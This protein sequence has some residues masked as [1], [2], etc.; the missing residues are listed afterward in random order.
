M[1]ARP[2]RFILAATALVALALAPPCVQAGSGPRFSVRVTSAVDGSSVAGDVTIV[3]RG[4]DVLAVDAIEVA[5]EA[6]LPVDAT[7]DGME[8]GTRRGAWTLARV[9][10]APPAPIAPRTTAR[11]PF[12]FALCDATPPPETRFL[13]SA[14]VVRSG[15]RT[16]AA[17]SRKSAA[18]ASLACATCGDGVVEGAEV[19]DGDACCSESCQPITEGVA[20]GGSCDAPACATCKD[21]CSNGEACAAACWEGF[22][23]CLGGCTSTY[24]APFCQVDYGRCAAACP[25]DGGCASGCETASGCGAGCTEP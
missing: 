20:C 23:Q 15:E 14:T 1:P 21:G 6:L 5:L 16:V 24:C 17:R 25:A 4:K 7:P 22:L 19:C 9:S 18:P 11:L 10:L 2:I 8:R 13:R 12:R 3:N